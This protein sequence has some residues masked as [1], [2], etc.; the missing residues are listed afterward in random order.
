MGPRLSV[1]NGSKGRCPTIRRAG[2]RKELT[3][4]LLL[5]APRNGSRALECQAC[6]GNVPTFTSKELYPEVTLF[7]S[8][9]TDRRPK[10]LAVYR[11]DSK[12][13]E[14][15][16]PAGTGTGARWLP[17]SRPILFLH[18]GAMYLVSLASNRFHHVFYAGPRGEIP[19][20]DLSK[21]GRWIVFTM[22]PQRR[23]TSPRSRALRSHSLR[24]WGK[25]RSTSSSRSS[26]MP[27]KVEE[28]KKRITRGAAG[29]LLNVALLR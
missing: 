13:Y 2:T 24:S 18:D 23:S 22:M 20:L 12:T 11:L 9:F 1:R 28:T 21:D 26:F 15:A 16:G 8:I 4:V 25:T 29:G 14:R 3:R 17:D 6:L 5:T 7:W 10:G 27:R 19:T